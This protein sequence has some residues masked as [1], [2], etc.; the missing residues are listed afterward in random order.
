MKRIRQG[1]SLGTGL[2]SVLSLTSHADNVTPA[3]PNIVLVMGDDMRWNDMGCYGNPD[4]YTPNIDRLAREGMR[5]TRCFTATAMC[6]PTRQQLYTGLF[7][8]R[9]GAYPNHS[10]V[11]P[12]VKSMPHYLK[13][14]GYRV[15]ITGKKHFGPPQAFPFVDLGDPL[16]VAKSEAFIRKAP[17][18]PFCLV[19]TSHNPHGPYTEGDPSRYNPAK[20][21]LPPNFLDSPRIRESLARYYAEITELDR[22]TGEF[23]KLIDRLGKT[24]NTI[25]IFTTEQGSS[26]PFGKWSCYDSGLRTG[27]II[28]WPAKV[29]PGSVTDA[30]VQYVDILPTLIEAAGG[31]PTKIKTGRPDANGYE[32]FD[33]HSFLAVLLGKTNTHNKYV[34]GVHTSYGVNNASLFPIRSIRSEHYKLIWNPRPNWLYANAC[35]NGLRNQLLTNKIEG[36]RERNLRLIKQFLFHPEY[37]LYDVEKDEYELVNLA[38]DPRYA[39]IKNELIT[40]LKAWCAQQGDVDPAQTEKNAINRQGKKRRA[41]TLAT[42][43]KVEKLF[44]FKG[45]QQ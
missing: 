5:F 17:D 12:T 40:R 1:L 19:V 15:A 30:M 6:A 16:S 9:N 7:P 29:K 43:Q 38:G 20:L 44:N 24:R 11:Y 37:E 36:D 26:F 39:K 35:A 33:G 2:L 42:R 10:H 8:V 27:L 25:F 21:T 32:G 3:K 14:L 4:V 41:R 34:Y 31:D 18:K 22:Q 45:E 23:M 13:A 28:R